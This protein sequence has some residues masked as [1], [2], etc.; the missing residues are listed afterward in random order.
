MQRGNIARV[1]LGILLLAAIVA[2]AFVLLRYLN[3]QGISDRES[4][5]HWL[6]MHQD[7]RHWVHTHP[8][9]APLAFVG[10]YLLLSTLMLPVWWV[11][12]LAGHFWGV[13]GGT[14]LCQLAASIAALA[15][16]QTSKWI[17]G[18]WFHRRVESRARILKAL[19]QRLGHNGFLVVMLTR[20]AHVVPFGPSNYAMG[21]IPI[22]PGAVFIGTLLGGIPTV[23]FYAACGEGTVTDWRVLATIAGLNIALLVPPILYYRRTHAAPPNKAA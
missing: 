8:I 12:V 20:L 4:A 21:L 19:D 15:A 5:R 7:V 2:G 9:A 22:V 11:Q 1:I 6:R 14:V 13:F 17:A 10:L 23:A 18:D 3:A 16:V